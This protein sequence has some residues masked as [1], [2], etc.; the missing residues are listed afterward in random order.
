MNVV[1]PWGLECKRDQNGKGYRELVVGGILGI[2]GS[3]NPLYGAFQGAMQAYIL[4]QME[5]DNDLECEAEDIKKLNDDINNGLDYINDD[6][7]VNDLLDG[8]L[9]GGC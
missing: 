1:D 3:K 7:N 2:P 5:V 4:N 6:E 9:N 8:F